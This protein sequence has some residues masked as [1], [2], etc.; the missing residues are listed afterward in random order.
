MLERLWQLWRAL[1][2]LFVTRQHPDREGEEG[3][4]ETAFQ[5]SCL[6]LVLIAALVVLM[7]WLS[8]Q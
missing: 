6:I 5:I 2:R 3:P 8:R 1:I 4:V 7:A